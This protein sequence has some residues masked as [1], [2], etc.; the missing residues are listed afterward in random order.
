MDKNLKVSVLLDFYG[1]L[2]TQKQRDLIDLYYNQDLSL[3][4]IS[5]LEHI[6]RQGAYDSIKRGEQFL[7]E[8]EE[9]LQMLAQYQKTQQVFAKIVVLSEK[10]MNHLQIDVA[11]ME[12][13]KEIRQLAQ[14]Q[15]DDENN[16]KPEVC[17]WL[18]KD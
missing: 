14:Q 11:R 10:L 3:G 4:E 9:K 5:Q 7:C 18:L 15:I 2:L 13:V 12:I 1:Q 16:E 8:L 6:T 17:E